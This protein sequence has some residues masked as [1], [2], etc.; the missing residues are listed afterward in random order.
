[1][2]NQQRISPVSPSLRGRSAPTPRSSP[3]SPRLN[4][5]LR[6]RS[7]PTPSGSPERSPGS[8]SGSSS[9]SS[10]IPDVN[11]PQMGDNAEML[12]WRATVHPSGNIGSPI[13]AEW[14]YP[15]DL[16]NTGNQN[17]SS[18]RQAVDRYMV[19]EY[20][21]EGVGYWTP[22]ERFE[23]VFFPNNS[24]VYSNI[25]HAYVEHSTSIPLGTGYNSQYAPPQ[26]YPRQFMSRAPE[27][28]EEVLHEITHN[29]YGKGK[30]YI[31]NYVNRYFVTPTISDNF[32]AEADKEAR[33]TIVDIFIRANREIPNYVEA[34]VEDEWDN[35]IRDEELFNNIIFD[36]N[37]YN[38]DLNV[39]LFNKKGK[40]L[41]PAN[42]AELRRGVAAGSQYTPRFNPNP[43]NIKK[44]TQ[45]RN[46]KL[47]K[48]YRS[49]LESIKDNPNLMYKENPNLMYGDDETDRVHNDKM[50]KLHQELRQKVNDRTKKLNDD[51]DD[52][53][54]RQREFYGHFGGRRATRRRK[55]CGKSK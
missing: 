13:N 24:G 25:P 55:F 44:R 3:G 29:L 16:P 14:E 22:G 23:N 15:G 34:F 6:G 19:I 43:K 9:G 48:E 1:M 27:L 18:I 5:R 53:L 11:E 8:S 12:L 42:K 51:R 37:Y 49:Y 50:N 7:A 31:R 21:N 32:T 17:R 41:R 26:Y 54:A 38:D 10:E 47:I 40:S 30:K 45:K 28:I 39:K 35:H 46:K 36:E 4:L 2:E 20:M 52:K 33:N